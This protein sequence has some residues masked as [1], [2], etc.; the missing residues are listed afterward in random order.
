MTVLRNRLPHHGDRLFITGGGIETTLL[1]REGIA[2]PACAT[3]VLLDEPA[4]RDWLWR[5]YARYARIACGQRVGLVLET[6]T[7]RANADWGDALGY[8]AA[9]LVRS[10]R[11]GIDLMVEFRAAHETASSPMPISGTIGPRG[12]GGRRQWMSAEQ[13]RRYHAPQIHTFAASR[14]DLVSAMTLGDS[15]EAIGIVAAARACAMPVVVSFTVETDGRLP[16]GESLCAA[17]GRTDAQTDG[18]AAYF[19]VDCAHPVHFMPAFDSPGAWQRRV[20]GLRANASRRSHAELDVCRD[21]DEGDPAALGLQHGELKRRMPWL[22]V[23]GGC[24]GT[25]HRHVDAICRS[26]R[27]ASR[28]DREAEEAAP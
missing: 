16:S 6:P 18:Y 22:R 26:A 19:M 12:D 20:L 21:L 11:T 5:Y 25:D 24:C 10:N 15:D 17:I 4:G 13:A 28:Y 2:L 8:D 27:N 9:A 1:H 23:L 3:F 14:A 7:W